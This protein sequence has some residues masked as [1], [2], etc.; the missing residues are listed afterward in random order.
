M[1]DAVATTELFDD[2][3]LYVAKFTN[4][5]DG[6]GESDVTKINVSDITVPCYLVQIDEIIWTCSGM[7]VNILWDAG[8]NVLAWTLPADT[9]GHINFKKEYGG[10][11]VNTLAASYTGDVVF[12][13]LGHA[14][15]EGYVI[16]LVCTK[17]GAQA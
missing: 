7:S 11:L 12:T 13:T 2:E 4:L 15:N 14:A 8:T 1:G 9:W 6:T 3:N 17:I 10:P 16:T 5:S